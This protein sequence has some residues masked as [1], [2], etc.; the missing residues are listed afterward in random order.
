MV[1]RLQYG[2]LRLLTLSSLKAVVF[3]MFNTH[4]L[5]P[6]RYRVL[7]KAM[8]ELCFHLSAPIPQWPTH[9]TSSGAI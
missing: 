7:P 5:H 8:N 2:A 9:N 3:H 6:V 1:P 4:L